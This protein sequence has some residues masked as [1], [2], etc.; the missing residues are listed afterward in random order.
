MRRWLREPQRF[1]PLRGVQSKICL[2]KQ[3]DNLY[4]SFL[5]IFTRTNPYAAFGLFFTHI[6]CSMFFLWPC[7]SLCFLCFYLF[8]F[9]FLLFGADS[10]VF[11]CV[12][13]CMC[14]RVFLFS[15]MC[16]RVLALYLCLRIFSSS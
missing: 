3:T 15:N 2:K 16:L 5:C 8:V 14:F 9:P 10:C 7:F 1:R 11:L 4:L 6:S 13:A 12:C